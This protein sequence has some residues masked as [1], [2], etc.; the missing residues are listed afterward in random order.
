MYDVYGWCKARSKKVGWVFRERLPASH[1]LGKA[2]FLV[3]LT[4]GINTEVCM[5]RCK[6]S[7]STR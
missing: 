1:M 3:M 2:Y 6:C 7:V 5:Q 4:V